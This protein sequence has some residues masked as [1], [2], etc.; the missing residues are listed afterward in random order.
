VFPPSS[1]DMT[2]RSLIKYSRPYFPLSAT[3]EI[4]AELRPLM[5][6]LDVTMGK[7]MSYYEM[8]LPTYR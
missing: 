3:K 1:L 6:P 2:L 8:F 7:A 5:C 4:L